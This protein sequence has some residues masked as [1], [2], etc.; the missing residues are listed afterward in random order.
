MFDVCYTNSVLRE[1]FTDLSSVL[2]RL[3]EKCIDESDGVRLDF[4]V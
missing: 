4:L 1:A 2:W 3:Q